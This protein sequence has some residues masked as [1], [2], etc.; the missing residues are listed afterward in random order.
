MRDNQ[1]LDIEEKFVSTAARIHAALNRE[2]PRPEET[3]LSDFL[4]KVPNSIELIKKDR[5]T[6]KAYYIASRA[7]LLAMAGVTEADL[8]RVPVELR[9]EFE[10]VISLCL[11]TQESEITRIQYKI[12]LS[13]EEKTI[14]SEA[15]TQQGY[16][17][18]EF[19]A[20]AAIYVASFFSEQT[21]KGCRLASLAD[22]AYIGL[23]TKNAFKPEEVTQAMDV[24]GITPSQAVKLMAE[25]ERL[26]DARMNPEA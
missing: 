8:E 11:K 25:L 24:V 18:S 3:E 7:A 1:R 12:S 2:M 21:A 19:A 22:L 5:R 4:D 13:S 20:R 15:A 16:T 10:N 26:R 17:W 9:K 14:I 23:E 6:G